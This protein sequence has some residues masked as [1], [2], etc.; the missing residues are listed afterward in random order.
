MFKLRN[1]FVVVLIVLGGVAWWLW[2]RRRAESEGLAGFAPIPSALPKTTPPP[3]ATPLKPSFA[4]APTKTPAST[5]PRR[6]ATRVHKGAPP[7]PPKTN[8]IPT[9]DAPPQALNGGSEPG[10][11]TLATITAS[12]ATQDALLE[13]ASFSPPSTPDEVAAPLQ[14]DEAAVESYEATVDGTIETLPEPATLTNINTA[15]V[16]DLVALPGI[17]PALA[18]RIIEYRD[19]NGPFATIDTLIDVQGIG[20]NNIAEFAHLITV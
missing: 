14:A 15:S 5:G 16:D 7:T 6:I 10:T 17:G 13:P 19:S 18:K 12:E 8:N 2:Q 11:E 9:D 4:K 1:L 20:P 3:A